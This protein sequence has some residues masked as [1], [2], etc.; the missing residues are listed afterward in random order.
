VIT[1]FLVGVITRRLGGERFAQDSRAVRPVAGFLGQD[2]YFS[3]N[4]FDLFWTLAVWLVVTDGGKAARLA[5]G[6][7]LGLGPL[8][9]ISMLWF[10]G[11]VRRIDPHPPG[12]CCARSGHGWRE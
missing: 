9:K 6:L 2:R 8:N 4:A 7:V 5:L 10:G 12:G 11:A 3:M 1:I